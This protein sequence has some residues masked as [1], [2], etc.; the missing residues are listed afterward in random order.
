MF[1]L[2]LF[3]KVTNI[4]ILIHLMIKIE[5][6][7]C[8]NITTKIM[9]SS[10][11]F[12]NIHRFS[13]KKK[14]V[15]SDSSFF[16]FW[17]WLNS[18]THSFSILFHIESTLVSSSEFQHRYLD[19]HLYNTWSSSSRSWTIAAPFWFLL[20]VERSKSVSGWYTNRIKAR[21]MLRMTKSDVDFDQN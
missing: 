2:N 8:G 3:F 16:L 19:Q 17:L 7:K 11:I 14:Y 13:S 12:Y 6:K 4:C 1:K 5:S 21:V 9:Y 18:I 15:S 10:R 20:H